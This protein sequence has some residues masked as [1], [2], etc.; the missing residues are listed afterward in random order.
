M[1]TRHYHPDG[2]Y[3]EDSVYMKTLHR[4][5]AR[6]HGLHRDGVTWEPQEKARMLDAFLAGAYYLGTPPCLASLLHR[7]FHGVMTMRWKLAVNYRRD[8]AA[9]G[10]ADDLLTAGTPRQDRAG[11]PFTDRDLYLVGLALSEQGR[12]HRVHT[13]ER[14]G[15]LL[16]R[17]A[18][19]VETWLAALARQQPR[20]LGLFA[21]PP[22]EEILVIVIRR[23]LAGSA[24]PEF[25][26]EPGFPLDEGG[27]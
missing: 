27:A 4:G 12:K 20:T 13:P 10:S 14:L 26:L 2:R 7:S 9:A 3:S 23:K 5:A 18:A 24:D 1:S 11:R 21:P 22:R 15:L 25:S 19:E 8:G 17:P 16:A 6:L